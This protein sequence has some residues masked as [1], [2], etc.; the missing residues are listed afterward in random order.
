MPTFSADRYDS[1]QYRRCGRSGLLL[2]A[3]SLGAWE[4]FGGYRGEDVARACLLR[5]FDLGITHF[6]L[7][8]NYGTPPGNAEIVC[9]KIIKEMPRDEL[10]I[11]SKAGY[12]MWPGPYGDFGSR[13]YIIASCDQSLKRMGLEYFDIFYSHRTD[14]D[15]PLE[16]TM[17]ALDQLVRQGK[18]LYVG[19]SNYSGAH[20]T[21][22]QNVCT[23]NRLA[24]ITIH[25]PYYNMLR[26]TVE[27]DILPQ[28]ERAGTGV[29]PFCPLA[30]GLLTDKYLGNDIPAESRAAQRW[31]K[32]W[33]EDN[34]NEEKRGKLLKLNEMAAKRGQTLAQM[35]LVWIL[36]LPAITSALIGA[37]SPQQIEEN[38][39]ALQNC[40]FSAEELQQIDEITEPRP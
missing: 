34:L 39:A 2:P 23:N 10:I 35:A 21:S 37:S 29:I 26:R 25:Q 6:D 7:A 14:P 36:R 16:E 31:G 5:A 27:W 12:T 22:A 33:L 30:S 1:M 3:I 13:K 32:K 28:T 19:V 38:V 18:A 4:T 20:F 9:G 17:G 15:T 8:N 40:D 24:P 11:S